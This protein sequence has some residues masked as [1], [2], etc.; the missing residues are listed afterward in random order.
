MKV[1][2]FVEGRYEEA[3]TRV[4]SDSREEVLRTYKNR[5]YQC[6]QGE[7]EGTILVR[8][9][10]ILA[11]VKKGEQLLTMNVNKQVC[12]LYDETRVSEELY[13]LFLMDAR[14]GKIKFE[15]SE[16]GHINLTI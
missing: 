3:D 14:E 1:L 9:A 7:G 13:E 6:I 5:G 12:N 15:L 2:K 8:P 4:I 10:K 16:D 11:Q